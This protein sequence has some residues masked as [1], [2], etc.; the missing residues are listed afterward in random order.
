MA[1]RSRGRKPKGEGPLYRLSAKCRFSPEAEAA[2]LQARNKSQFITEAIEFYAKIGK[3]LKELKKMLATSRILDP[4][5]AIPDE[6]IP[7]PAPVPA[8]EQGGPRESRDP[9]EY[10][11]AILATLERFLKE[12]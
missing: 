2:Y 10:Y 1:V 5:P 3:E 4:P 6:I 11:E 8:S 7:R 9:P 12:G